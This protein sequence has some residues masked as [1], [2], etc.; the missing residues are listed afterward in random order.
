MADHVAFAEQRDRRR[1]AHDRVDRLAAAAERHAHPVGALLLLQR[2]HVEHQRRARREIGQRAGLFLG[3]LDKLIDGLHAELGV[4][5][6]HVDQVEGVGDRNEA[7]L[8]IERQPLEQ[9][10][11]VEHRIGI[12]DADGV[13]VGR[14]VRAGAGAG[15]HRSARPVLDDQRLAPFDAQLLAERAHEDVGEAAGAGG[16]DRLDRAARPVVLR[17]GGSSD[18]GGAERGEA[19]VLRASCQSFAFRE[20]RWWCPGGGAAVRR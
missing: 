9:E 5:H 7:G 19:A 14:R 12:G 6:Q 10:L 16:G 1:P 4:H 8:R 11:V 3:Q 15:V 20:F 13:A 2:L 18:G 17:R